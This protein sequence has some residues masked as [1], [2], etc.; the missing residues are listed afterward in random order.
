L[1]QG[2]IAMPEPFQCVIK[3]RSDK[4]AQMVKQIW[5]EAQ[6]ELDPDTMQWIKTPE[7]MSMPKA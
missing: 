6:R 1:T 5:H 4:K 3:P 2:F 7:G